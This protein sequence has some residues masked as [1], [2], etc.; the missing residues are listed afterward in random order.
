MMSCD[1]F[2]VY[3]KRKYKRIS[4]RSQRD[5][6][7]QDYDQVYEEYLELHKLV[8]VVASTFQKYQQELS[9]IR[10]D[11]SREYQEKKKRVVSDYLEKVNDPEY[12]KKRERY[13][14]VY[15]RLNYIHD[16]CKQYDSTA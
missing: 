9:Q 3:L 11:S 6:Y 10:D 16:L 12:A 1:R 5:Q 13:V 14:Q 15:T 4:S 8:D 2:C 7:Q